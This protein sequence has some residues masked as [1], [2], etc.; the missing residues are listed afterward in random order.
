MVRDEVVRYLED[1]AASF[2]PPILEGVR[3]IGLQRTAT[4]VFE[5]ST[6][7]GDMTADQVVVATGPYHTRAVPRMGERLPGDLVQLHSSAYWLFA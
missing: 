5:L 2:R 4:G 7:A 1:Y 3:V 6:S